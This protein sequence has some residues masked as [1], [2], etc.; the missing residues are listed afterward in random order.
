MYISVGI[1]LLSALFLTIAL[2]YQA[3]H[4]I[5]LKENCVGP[6]Y[7]HIL[8]LTKGGEN[9]KGKAGKQQIP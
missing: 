1:V 3:I 2:Y 9:K 5:H 4:Y 7:G 8:R 6:I